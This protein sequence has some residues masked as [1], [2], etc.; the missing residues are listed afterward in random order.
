[1]NNPIVPTGKPLP[2]PMVLDDYEEYH[3]YASQAIDT[4]IARNTSFTADDLRNM[5]P[6]PT[7]PN[8]TGKVFQDYARQKLIVKTGYEMARSKVRRGGTLARWIGV[9]RRG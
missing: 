5:T 6:A 8:W 9:M 1:M 4:L 7:N 2:V 3:D